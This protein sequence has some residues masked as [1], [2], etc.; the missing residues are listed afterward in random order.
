MNKLNYSDLVIETQ[1]ITANMD[2]HFFLMLFS[3]LLIIVT[4]ILCVGILLRQNAL[5]GKLDLLTLAME[6][7][8][9]VVRDIREALSKNTD[10]INGLLAFLRESFKK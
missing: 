10:A 9:N 3:C 4:I 8:D 2:K 1:T 5:R 6:H 7:G